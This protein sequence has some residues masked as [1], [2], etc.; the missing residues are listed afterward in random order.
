MIKGAQSSTIAVIRSHTRQ[1]Q[2][3]SSRRGSRFLEDTHLFMK[4]FSR[5]L[6]K[7]MS[8]QRQFVRHVHGKP[9]AA[10]FQDDPSPLRERGAAG[11]NPDGAV[12]VVERSA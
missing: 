5:A 11:D 10:K 6:R 4:T 12:V 9:A 1:T 2:D 7:I 8:W 3:F